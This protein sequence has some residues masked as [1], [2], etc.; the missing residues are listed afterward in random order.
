MNPYWQ[1]AEPASILALKRQNS[2]SD[3][4]LAA[5]PKGQLGEEGASSI[6]VDT[7][8]PQWYV[9]YTRSRHEKQVSRHLVERSIESFLPLFEVSHRWKDRKARLELPLF[10]GYVFV[11]IA[12]CE[13]LSVLQIP[14]VVRLVGFN[15]QPAPIPEAD[16]SALQRGLNS[17]VR[18]NPHPYLVVG[19]P[20]KI[21]RGPFVGLKGILIRRKGLYRVV[22]SFHLIRSSIAVEVEASDV[23][24]AFG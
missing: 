11:R 12:L 23:S 15:G 3:T 2:I 24:P 16:V 4:V 13:Q 9:A 1:A 20:V 14:G 18:V 10:P 19:R 22:V 17:A 7:P 6:L 8:S 5:F 21:C